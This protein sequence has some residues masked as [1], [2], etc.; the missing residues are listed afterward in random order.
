[1]LLRAGE[2]RDHGA[3]ASLR[4]TVRLAISVTSF[5]VIA[6]PNVWKSCTSN[7]KLLGPPVTFS[8]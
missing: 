8:R 4:R 3:A 2:P 7:T 1:M 5:R 6:S